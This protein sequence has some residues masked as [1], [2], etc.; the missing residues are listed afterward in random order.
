[1]V[2]RI[3]FWDTISHLPRLMLVR[4][5]DQFVNNPLMSRFAVLAIS[6]VFELRLNKPPFKGPPTI[7]NIGPHGEDRGE[8]ACRTVEEQRAVLGCWLLSSM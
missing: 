2:S 5:H 8:V 4:G 3:P 1:M 6:M 7:F